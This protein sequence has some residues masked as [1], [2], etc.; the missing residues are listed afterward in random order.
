MLPIDT[1]SA[2]ELDRYIGKKDAA[3]IDLRTPEEYRKS[4][5]RT[6]VNIPYEKL[7]A[8]RQFSRKKQLILYCERGSSSLFAARELTKMGYQVKSVV[9]GIRCYQGSNLFFST[10]HSRIKTNQ[11]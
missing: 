9:G 5:I 6:A 11:E 8:C 3:I 4:H 10:E 7:N 2:G 1:I